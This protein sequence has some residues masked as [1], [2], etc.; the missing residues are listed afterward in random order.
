VRSLYELEHKEEA[1][2]FRRF[3]ERSA[4][5]HRDDLQICFGVGGEHRLPEIELTELEGYRGAAPVRFGNAAARQQQHDVYGELLELAWRWH[6]EGH[7]PE[8]HYW[9][10]LVELADA[11]AERWRDPD[12]GIWELRHDPEH[13]VHSKVMCWAA[14]DRGMALAEEAGLEAP[15]DRWRKVRDEVREAVQ[16]E[17][18][19]EER[20]VFVRT[21]GSRD[22]DGALLLLP[23]VR[24]L[25]WDDGRMVRTADAIRE[26]LEADGLI[27]RFKSDEKEGA[28]LPCSFWMAEV[29][30]RQGRTEEARKVFDQA[31]G[32]ANDLGLLAEE[33]DPEAGEMLGNFPQGLTHL[34]HISAALALA[35][36]PDR[37]D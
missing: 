22:L 1:D 17:G 36:H 28:F 6:R 3:V 14:L 30:A 16:S 11:A 23:R 33:F 31:M 12:R 18:Y 4:A 15:T 20:G 2:G 26:D 5:G 37:L 8:P 7:E 24:F 10:F 32:T 34:S 25:D 35:G 13:W 19:D 21:F 27:Y 29:L 9:E